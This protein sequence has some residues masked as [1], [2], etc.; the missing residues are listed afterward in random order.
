MCP[1][2]DDREPSLVISPKKNL[3]HCL[4]AC[5]RGG[6]PIDWVIAA[7]GVSFRHAVELLR[8]DAAA[9]AEKA[10]WLQP[11]CAAHDLTFCPRRQIE[12]FGMERGR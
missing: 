2:H 5:Q 11:Y 9:L 8:T 4:G 1:F 6:G 10:R 12:W 3:W 7:Q